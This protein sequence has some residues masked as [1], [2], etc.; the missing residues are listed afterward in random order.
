MLTVENSVKSQT[1]AA[2]IIEICMSKIHLGNLYLSL[3]LVAK[4]RKPPL[5]VSSNTV[6]WFFHQKKIQN[7]H[8]HTHTHVPGVVG[9]STKNIYSKVAILGMVITPLIGILTYNWYIKPY[10]WVDDHPLLYGNN[11]SLDPSTY[12]MCHSFL[13]ISQC[14]AFNYLL[15][16][17]YRID[18]AGV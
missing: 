11:G 10:Y 17:R 5:K 1:V 9:F 2:L 13:R 16:H 6:A 7:T 18:E 4:L 3:W 12:N 14:H 15:C 8:T